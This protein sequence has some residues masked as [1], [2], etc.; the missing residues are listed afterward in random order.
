MKLNRLLVLGG[1]VAFVIVVT[2]ILLLSS[3]SSNGNL[4]VL[5]IPSP[6][7]LTL[8]NKSIKVGKQEVSPGKHTIKANM[9]GFSSSS[10]T[11]TVGSSLT[12]VRIILTPNSAAGRKYMADHPEEQALIEQ[13]DGQNFQDENDQGLANNPIAA[14]LPHVA[15]DKSY[16]VDIGAVSDTSTKASVYITAVNTDA[17]QAARSWLS[18][19]GYDLASPELHES[20]EPLLNKLPYKTTDYLIDSDYVVVNG[21]LKMTLSITITLAQAD[22][23]DANAAIA[24]HKQAALDH[25]RS[26]GVDPGTYAI[27]YITL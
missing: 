23:G 1:S 9:A 27:S 7:K 3:G 11:V 10:R 22:S 8:D 6:A 15:S 14:E 5:V 16:R 13:Y 25:L 20:I 12:T 4:E 26:V 18:T 2:L 17:M 21:A 19:R 24:E